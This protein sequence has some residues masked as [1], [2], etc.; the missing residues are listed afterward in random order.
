VPE[1]I[2][3]PWPPPET[4]YPTTVYVNK[5]AII[6]ISP[7]SIYGP[8]QAYQEILD[9]RLTGGEDG[10]IVCAQITDRAGNFAETC[11]TTIL[12]T[13]PPTGTVVIDKGVD[14][15]NSSFVVLDLYAENGQ[16]GIDKMQVSNYPSYNLIKNAGFSQGSEGWDQY[17]YGGGIV[18]D[19]KTVEIYAAPSP[20]NGG[21]AEI[22]HKIKPY[23][24]TGKMDSLFTISLYYK[25][26]FVDTTTFGGVSLYYHYKDGTELWR[27][28]KI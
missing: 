11:D 12:E 1:I 13:T 22:T 2:V 26:L 19:L 16:S 25:R 28:A 18:F 7:D 6:P 27:L 9:W 3:P 8:W 21:Y 17:C 23:Y 15:T 24:F 5:L 14:T 20:S 4:L 10:H